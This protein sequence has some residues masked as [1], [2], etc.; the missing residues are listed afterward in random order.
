MPIPS[1]DLGGLSSKSDN[2]QLKGIERSNVFPDGIVKIYFVFSLTEFS[3][4][5]SIIMIPMCG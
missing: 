5:F 2:L 4:N 1:N 3:E